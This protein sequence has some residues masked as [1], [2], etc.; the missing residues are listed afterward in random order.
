VHDRGV[1]R[2]FIADDSR[3]IRERLAELLGVGRGMQIVGVATDVTS[4][5]ENIARTRPDLAILDLQMPGGPVLDLIG[6]LKQGQPTLR[7]AV[8][9]AHAADYRERILAA[10]ADFVV[11]KAREIQQIEEIALIVSNERR[12]LADLA[13]DRSSYSDATPLRTSPP[14]D[15]RVVLNV[16]D[17]KPSLYARTRILRRAG[18]EVIE[19][20]T[21]EEALRLSE[22][23]QPQL[24]LLDVHLP[25]MSGLEVCRR[26]KASRRVPVVHISATY[27]SECDRAEGLRFSGADAY[28]TEP[29]PGQALV[30]IIEGF[31]DR[32]ATERA[33]VADKPLEE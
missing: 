6:R 22:E 24:V 4:A 11:H 19:A 1:P 12:T 5:E 14:A 18:F 3:A 29:V 7:I 13:T 17:Y 30:D 9:S 26:I 27:R 2:V 31:F 15:T 33:G 23:Q 16:D 32:R 20:L 10:G 25:D 28:L 8:M 21:G